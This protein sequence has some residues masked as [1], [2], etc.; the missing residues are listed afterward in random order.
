MALETKGRQLDNLDTACKRDWSGGMHPVSDKGV[1][2]L[3]NYLREPSPER[4][5]VPSRLLAM[6]VS[7]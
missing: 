4:P 6:W 5:A 1:G 7:A 3:P 2:K